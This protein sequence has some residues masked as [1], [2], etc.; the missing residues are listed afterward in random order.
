MMAAQ[1]LAFVLVGALIA[2]PAA[3][4]T[5][6]PP[7]VTTQVSGDARLGGTV[8][9]DVTARSYLAGKPLQLVADPQA[10][11]QGSSE[12]M[13]TEDDL[14]H[15]WHLLVIG[16]GFW[17]ASLVSDH[18]PLDHKGRCCVVAWSGPDAGV[19]DVEQ[20]SGFWHFS[21]IVTAQAT[22]LNATWVRLDVSVITE[23]ARLEGATLSTRV[24]GRNGTSASFELAE[25]GM[26]TSIYTTWT[27]SLPDPAGGPH[28]KLGGAVACRS[29]DLEW[30]PS[31]EVEVTLKPC[32]VLAGVPG[33]SAAG[34]ITAVALGLAIAGFCRLRRR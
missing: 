23:D 10:Q 34:T 20:S 33:A 6:P 11:V 25:R 12:W 2:L 19:V 7:P 1:T 5:S 31:R 22:P 28:I 27:R 13:P 8:V 4:G 18:G 30:T 29:A 14:H 17:R 26:G 32:P 9:L 3:I 24:H 16:Q 21:N 15:R